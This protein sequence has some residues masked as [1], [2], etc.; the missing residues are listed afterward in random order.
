[1]SNSRPSLATLREVIDNQRAL[2]RRLNWL[3]VVPLAIT[4]IMASM[5]F[6]LNERLKDVELG[7]KLVTIERFLV[8]DNNL[9]WAEKQYEDL[10]KSSPSAAILARL[11]VLY[12]RL[13]PESNEKK[14][15]EYLETAKSYDEK[16]W[17]IYRNLTFIYTQTGR[18]EKAI[19]AGLKATE[20]NERDAN[21]WNN[22]AW[23]YYKCGQPFHS[24][25]KAR[26]SAEKAVHLTN[27]N[28]P[29]FLDTLA[30][31]YAERGQ[32]DLAREKIHRAILIA[33][34]DQRKGL[35]DTFKKL[36]PDEMLAESK[37]AR[38]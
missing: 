17:E 29:Q 35:N 27:E 22:L 15:V 30:Q 18:C 2:G 20:L 25:N 28:N 34:N 32:R 11:G 3:L 9:E 14:A 16:N 5:F 21:S 38:R 4:V 8:T 6:T 1:M 31:V 24:L 7:A 36:F 37:E 26:T 13:D 33:P 23:N 12:F 19:E 10:A